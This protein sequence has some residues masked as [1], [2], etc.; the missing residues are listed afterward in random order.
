MLEI[1]A[2]GRNGPVSAKSDLESGEAVTG[3]EP[4]AAALHAIEAALM[5]SESLFRELIERSPE[6]VLVSDEGRIVYANPAMVRAAGAASAEALLGRRALDLVHPDEHEASLERLRRVVATNAAV[7]PRE[8]RCVRDDGTDLW[9][10]TLIAPLTLG[11][12]PTMVILG[13]DVTERRRQGDLLRAA[14]ER[15]RLTFEHAPIG[16]AMTGLDGRWIRVNQA[17]CSMLGYTADELLARSFQEVTHPDDLAQDLALV[18]ELYRGERTFYEHPKRYIRKDGATIDVLLHVSLAHGEDGQ[19]RHFI[20]HMID[21]TAQRQAERAMRESEAR[22]STIARQVP[23]GIFEIN[24]AGRYTSVNE[25][26]RQLTRCTE[27]EALGQPW[28]FI[29]HPDD[30]EMVTAAWVE[31]GQQGREFGVECRYRLADGHTAW[32]YSTAVAVRDDDSAVMGYLG[33]VLDVSERKQ[34]QA[35][36]LFNDRMASVGTLASGVAHEINNPLAYVTANLDLIVEEVRSLSAVLPADR[37]RDI[38]ELASEGRQGAEK[39]RRIVRALKTFARADEER[40]VRLDVHS[41]LDLSISMVSTELR[42][43]ARVVRDYQWVPA[44][45]A[46]EARLGQVF[47]NLLLNAAQALPEGMADRNTIRVV[48]RTNPAGRVFIEVHD[49]G[50]GIAPEH[51]GQIFDPF[52]TTRPVGRGIGL[53]LSI[54]HGIVAALGGEITVASE[55]GQGAT[56]VVSLPGVPVEVAPEAMPQAIAETRKRDGRIL[57]VDDDPM[58]G[59]TLRRVLERDHEVTVVESAREALTLIGAGQRYDVILCDVMMPQMTGIELHTELG[60]LAADQQERMI[61]VTGGTFTPKARAFFDKA[62]N[63]LIEKPFNLRNLR[64]VVR[65]QLQLLRAGVDLDQ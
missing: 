29:L 33:T 2:R 19:P 20:A 65:E 32:V 1:P 10:E 40:R 48:T 39:V 46:D 56:F 37:V 26:W 49:S 16:V 24:L 12:R 62:P 14:E 34:A 35:Q 38:E 54:C 7:E 30:R 45:E 44:V 59:T 18:G 53:G 50:V 60:R 41:V 13:R 64:A 22:A 21:I 51:R 28:D 15:F 55:P 52:F 17:L 58:V 4:R 6:I 23:V 43:R 47:I 11:G 25:R 42:R 9:M 3:G 57:V 63:A 61:F 5:R 31:A 36:L 27:D 8:V